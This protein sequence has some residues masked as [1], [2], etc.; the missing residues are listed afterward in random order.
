M[1]RYSLP[2]VSLESAEILGNLI[3]GDSKTNTQEKYL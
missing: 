2:E 1:W 3:L